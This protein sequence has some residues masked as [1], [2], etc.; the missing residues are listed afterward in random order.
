[1][2]KKGVHPYVMLA[3][4]AVTRCL[5]GDCA[6]PEGAEAEPDESVW[7][8]KRACFVSIKTTDGKL[9]GCIGTVLPAFESIDREIAANAISAAVRDHRFPPM[10]ADEL[11]G[12]IFSVD[13]LTAPEPVTEASE[14]DPK[15]W[16]VIVS[17]GARRGVLLP[18]LDGVYDVRTQLQIAAA[19]AGISDMGVAVIERFSVE[20][21]KEER[22][23]LDQQGSLR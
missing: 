23:P 15:V 5:T 9:R 8:I 22:P 14:L 7:N 20:R 1:M 18:N 13:V 11:S 4:L 21:Y 6:P 2:N 17:K 10:T 12:V 3:R 16:G 19:K